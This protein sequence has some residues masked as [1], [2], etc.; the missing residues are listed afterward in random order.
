M[1]YMVALI[2]PPDDKPLFLQDDEE[3]VMLFD[4]PDAADNAAQNNMAARA[5]GYEIIEW[6]F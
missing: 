5:W 3:N 4:G 6:P 2:K 1:R